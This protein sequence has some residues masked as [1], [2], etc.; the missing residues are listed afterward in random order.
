MLTAAY[1]VLGSKCDASMI[2]TL[3]HGAS[4]GGVTLVHVAPPLRVT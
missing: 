3:A 2:E 1:A 4:A